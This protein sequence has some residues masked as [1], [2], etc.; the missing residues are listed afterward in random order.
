MK[1][2]EH[3]TFSFLLAEFGARQEFG[4]K[5]TV[6]VIAAGLMPD[7]DGLTLLG[8][9]RFYR[10]YHRIVGHGLP[11]T[12]LG[13]LALAWL[14][15]DWLG[16]ARFLPLWCWLQ[17]SLLCH[18]FMD[19]VFYNWPVKLLWPASRKAWAVGLLEWND[20]VPTVLLYGATIVVLVDPRAAFPAACAGIGGLALYLGWRAWRPLPQSGWLTWVT[21]AWAERA[22][23]IWKWLTG[24]F[25]T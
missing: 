11:V 9:W 6:L 18:L 20:L 14:G 16:D 3:L 7:L 4:W 1:L 24:D 21:G 22:A 5:G 2:P 23:P 15:S 10:R 25:V 17:L 12:L 19:L 13:P 8:G